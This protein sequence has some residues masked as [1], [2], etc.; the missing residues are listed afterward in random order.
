MPQAIERWLMM[1]VIKARLPCRNPMMSP[2]LLKSAAT[3]GRLV[4]FAITD[5]RIRAKSAAMDGRFVIFAITDD[6]KRMCWQF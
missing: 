4:I 3:D 2:L 5:D 6:R 1:P